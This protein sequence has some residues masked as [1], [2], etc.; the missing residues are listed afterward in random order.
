MI[1][2]LTDIKISRLNIK[3]LFIVIQMIIFIRKEIKNE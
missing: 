3:T 1:Y 2:Y